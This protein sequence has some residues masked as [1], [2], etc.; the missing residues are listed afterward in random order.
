MTTF[1]Q[2]EALVSLAE[3]G[4]F[5]GAAERIGI[6]QSAVSRHIKEFEELFGW[7][8]LDRT[9]RA[10]RLTLEGGE[11]LARARTILRQRDAII[12]AVARSDVIHRRVRFGVT[13]L[14]ALTW[15][16]RL[17]GLMRASFP[18]VTTE[19]VVDHS[20]ALHGGLIAGEI[21][22][23]FVPDV[24]KSA[25]LPSLPLANVRHHWCC[26][27]TFDAPSTEIPASA[28]AAY[29]LLMQQAPSGIA[30]VIEPWLTKAGGR[31]RSSVGTASLVALAGMA[32]SG[33]GIALLPTAVCSPLIGT[34]VLC[35]VKVNPPLP[36]IP[37]VALTRA[38]AATAFHQR[39]IGLSQSC[40]D[41][42]MSYQLQALA[43]AGKHSEMR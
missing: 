17:M 29:P 12:D 35:E 4:T 23:A 41:F 24:F 7:P 1:R 6:V 32:L 8:L 40:C 9:G 15:L 22:L 42:E 26:S 18:S 2:L 10:A 36:E 43:K 19:L 3:T 16:P 20:L 38:D 30:T 11:V 21:D 34:G 39:I 33:L 13:E 5:E 27:P 25:T 28:L 31:S 14:C 37:Y